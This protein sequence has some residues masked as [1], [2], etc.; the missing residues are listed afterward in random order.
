MKKV[1]YDKRASRK[2]VKAAKMSKVVEGREESNEQ[3][4]AAPAAKKQR[5]SSGTVFNHIFDL[6]GCIRLCPSR[7]G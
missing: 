2:I 4:Q 6:D 3:G 1:R 5:L 7:L